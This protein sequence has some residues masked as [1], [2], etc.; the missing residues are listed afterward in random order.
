MK[1]DNPCV[2]ERGIFCGRLSADGCL[3]EVSCGGVKR[4]RQSSPTTT[5]Q[6]IPHDG[7]IQPVYDCVVVVML[8]TRG[9]MIV[10]ANDLYWPHVGYDTDIIAY[11]PIEI[12]EVVR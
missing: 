11:C 9:I 5:I 1:C 4:V 12:K 2:L 7:I 3:A 6:L 10:K 8:R